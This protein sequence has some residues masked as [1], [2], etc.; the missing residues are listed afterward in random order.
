MLKLTCKTNKEDGFSL[1]EMLVVT[2]VFLAVI[3]ISL[4]L[5]KLANF[6]VRTSKNIN[7]SYMN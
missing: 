7:E 5:I 3:A 1:V 2:V 4:Q 6:D